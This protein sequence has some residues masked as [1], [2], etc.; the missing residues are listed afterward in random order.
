MKSYSSKEDLIAAIRLSYTKFIQEFKDIPASLG[1]KRSDLVDKTPAEMLAYQ[2]GWI[3]LL[4]SWDEQ[5]LAGVEVQTPTPNYKWNELG[6]LYQ[7]FYRQ[8]ADLSLKEL[9]VKLDKSVVHLIDW[10]KSLDNQDLFEPGQKK[11]ATTKAMWP[12]WKWIHI[13]SV[14]PFTNFRPKIR[15]WKKAVLD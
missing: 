5:E 2:L 9:Q 11:W 14:A 4:L 7:D 13:N 15:K 6:N 3:A 12:V 1:N 8:Y 10:V